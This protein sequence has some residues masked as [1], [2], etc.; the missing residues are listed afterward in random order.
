MSNKIVYR[1][2]TSG[3]QNVQKVGFVRAPDQLEISV[4]EEGSVEITT[5][6]TAS[7]AGTTRLEGLTRDEEVPRTAAAALVERCRALGF[8]EVAERPLA[9]RGEAAGRADVER[10]LDRVVD[11][12]RLLDSL[13]ISVFED[14]EVVVE[15]R[16]LLNPEHVAGSIE[17]MALEMEDVSRP[18]SGRGS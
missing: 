1:G 15:A 13:A 17:K 10:V 9:Y 3:L 16:G 5:R 4:S 2:K 11:K 8:E 7:L 12:L 6:G 18:V 14:G